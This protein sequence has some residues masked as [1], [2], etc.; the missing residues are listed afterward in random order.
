M[1]LS[2]AKEILYLKQATIEC[3]P[4]RKNGEPCAALYKNEVEE[5]I[6]VLKEVEPI[7][8]RYRKSNTNAKK[9]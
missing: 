1:G 5:L 3:N 7:Y 9:S 4:L 6:E 2:R 8:E